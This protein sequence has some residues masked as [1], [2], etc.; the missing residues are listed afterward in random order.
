VGGRL[1][2]KTCLNVSQRVVSLSLRHLMR[3]QFQVEQKTEGKENEISRKFSFFNSNINLLWLSVEL[4]EVHY[5]YINTHIH[6]LSLLSFILFYSL[7]LLLSL[8]LSCYSRHT[9]L[10]RI[11]VQLPLGLYSNFLRFKNEH[12]NV[13]MSL[14]RESN[15]Y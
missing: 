2:V 6:T 3:C 7:F 13:M 14:R 4:R 12:K 9:F 10:C 15:Q 8:S 11:V 1:R 5:S